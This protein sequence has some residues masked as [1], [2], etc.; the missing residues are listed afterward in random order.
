MVFLALVVLGWVWGVAGL[1]LA[2]PLMSCA[3]LIAERSEHGH[4]VTT[5]LSR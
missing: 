1:L 4:T 2:V 5:L 3:K